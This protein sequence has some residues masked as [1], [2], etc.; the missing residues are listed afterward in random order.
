MGALPNIE[1]RVKPGERYRHFKGGL[2][3]VVCQAIQES[4]HSPVVV[5]RPL[6]G[7]S[8]HTVWT[9]PLEV[10]FEQVQV[11]ERTTQRFTRVDGD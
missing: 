3:E 11:G 1:Q 6:G 8:A 9:R 2:Y 5:Y 7:E 10:F 4:D